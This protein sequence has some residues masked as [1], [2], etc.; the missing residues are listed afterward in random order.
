MPG[1]GRARLRD[2]RAALP[3]M[4]P[5]SGLICAMTDQLRHDGSFLNGMPVRIVNPLPQ[6]KCRSV[7]VGRIIRTVSTK[8]TTP[9]VRK[10]NRVGIGLE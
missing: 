10:R 8:P 1:H 5:T 7:Y 6:A 4:S 2:D 9:H 3:S